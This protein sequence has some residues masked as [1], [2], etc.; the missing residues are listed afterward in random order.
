MFYRCAPECILFLRFT[1]ASDVW[2]FGVCLWEMFTYGFQ[3]WAAFSGQQILEAIDAP[4]FQVCCLLYF[5]AEN[6]IT[7]IHTKINSL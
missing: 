4:N 1:S 7:F 2:A 6:R 5:F 3:P